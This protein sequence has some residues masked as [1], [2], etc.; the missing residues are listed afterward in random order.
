MDLREYQDENIGVI[1]I[2][3]NIMEYNI[4]IMLNFDTHPYW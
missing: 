3:E 4:I 2:L 1:K